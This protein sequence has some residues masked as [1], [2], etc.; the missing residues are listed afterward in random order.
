MKLFFLFI[1]V[2][3][4]ACNSKKSSIEGAYELFNIEYG[5]SVYSKDSYANR[6]TIKL[7]KNGHWMAATFFGTKKITVES[8]NGGTYMLKGN[9]YIETVE[10]SSEGESEFGKICNSSYQLT[11]NGFIQ[12]RT[13]YNNQSESQSFEEIYI[14]LRS[15]K[16][17]QDTSME[18][19][20]TLR[21]SEWFGQKTEDND[22]IHLKIYFY[23]RFAWAAYHA[24]GKDF[25]GVGGGTYQCDGKK[26]VEHLEYFSFYDIVPG[27][28]KIDIV[29][30]SP[31]KVQ[32]INLASAGKEIY[33]K[34]R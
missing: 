22:L 8:A 10:F 32:L 27:D 14:R 31:G 17:L 33:D 18:G 13:K 23:P 1:I 29:P 6:R 30:V 16:N 3:L 15:D 7:I 5:D 9:D 19:V 12:Q 26:L 28:E 24:K 2:V 25:I 21:E 4:I 34:V 11:K 20:W